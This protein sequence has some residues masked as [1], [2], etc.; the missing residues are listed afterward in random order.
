ME[1]SFLGVLVDEHDCLVATVNYVEGLEL[2]GFTSLRR[3][4]ERI[5]PTEHLDLFYGALN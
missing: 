4:S 5:T 2:G 1:C 3:R